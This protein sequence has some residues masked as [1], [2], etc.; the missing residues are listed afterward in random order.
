MS[1]LGVVAISIGAE[2][3]E[4][5]WQ[6]ADS[7]RGVIENGWRLYRRSVFLFLA[8]HTGY[9]YVL[10]ISLRYDVLNGPIIGMLAFK[11][12]DIFFKLELIG[13]FRG[14]KRA[15]AEVQAMLESSIPSWYMFAGVLT[16]PWFVY[17]ALKGGFE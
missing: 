17:W 1:L 14:K 10:F 13:Y 16:Y 8:M 6:R 7:M 2:L 12:L 11:T 4:A 3:F 9:V 15:G 5:A